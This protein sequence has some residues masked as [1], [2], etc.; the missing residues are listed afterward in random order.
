LLG[1]RLSGT[2]LREIVAGVDEAV[3]EVMMRSYVVDVGRE[4]DL[5]IT[6]DDERVQVS[7]KNDGACFDPAAPAVKGAFPSLGIELIRRVF[8]DIRH[9]YSE[10]GV[11]HLVLGRKLGALAS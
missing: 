8:D 9:T 11:N 4:L 7:I 3:S 5:E 1:S 2:I 6:L 10:Q